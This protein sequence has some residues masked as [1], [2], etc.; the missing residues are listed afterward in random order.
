[1]KKIIT[2]LLAVLMLFSVVACAK[3]TGDGGKT[4][5]NNNNN[6]VDEKLWDKKELDFGGYEFVILAKTPSGSIDAWDG[7][8]IDCDELSGNEV[9]DAVYRRNKLIEDKYNCV[10]TLSD[11]GN[12]SDILMAGNDDDV[13]LVSSTLHTTI[14]NM[15]QGL[16]YDINDPGFT[17]FNLDKGWYDQT[18]QQE[19]TIKN[20]LYLISGDM[21]FTDENG[22]W[23][24]LFNKSLAEQYVTDVNLYDAVKEGKWTVDM[25]NKYAALATRE[26]DGNDTMDQ[27]DQW[28]YVGEEVNPWVMLTAGGYHLAQ[29][30]PDG[31]VQVNVFDADFQEAFAKCYTTLDQSFSLMAWDIKNP[32]VTIWEDMNSTFS[33]GRA[34][35]LISSMSRAL[36][37]REMTNDFGIL[38]IPKITEA[39][40][41]YNSWTTYNTNVISIPYF[42]SDQERTS[43]IMEALFEE[44][45][46]ELRDAYFEEALKYKATRDDESIEILDIIV[47]NRV[48][49]IGTLFNFGGTQGVLSETCKNRTINSL[50]SNLNKCKSKVTED[51]QALK[52][53]LGI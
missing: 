10:I 26:L 19:F 53:V 42:C 9:T 15:K 39:Q 8:D 3:T 7:V 51:I 31:D 35:F 36:T 45:S 49:D 47:D 14:N 41:G 38:P 24:T 34:L 44:S 16:L 1:M 46:F 20:S 12:I 5:N 33:E 4:D 29:F 22:A 17:Y 30:T 23:V 37:F 13:A 18:I 6:D 40:E 2:L 43:A 52:S 28:G 48:Y 32:T 25:L 27:N 11:P 50:T 21:L